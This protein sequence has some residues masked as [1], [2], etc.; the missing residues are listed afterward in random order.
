MTCDHE[1][2]GASVE[3]MAMGD[4]L[5]FAAAFAAAFAEA[6][7]HYPAIE[8]SHAI[9]EA[10][11][12]RWKREA[13][14]AAAKQAFGVAIGLKLAEISAAEQVEAADEGSEEAK[15]A[16]L[17]AHVIEAY[18]AGFD[19]EGVDCPYARDGMCGGSPECMT[20]ECGED[21]EEVVDPAD[22][23]LAEQAVLADAERA[24]GGPMRM[25]H[26]DGD[27]GHACACETCDKECE[28][29]TKMTQT[30]AM[31]NKVRDGQHDA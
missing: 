16:T 28:H 24:F 17:V 9:D 23:S 1:K 8:G 19:P 31:L 7:K 25:V 6:C 29:R 11:L 5:I 21:D 4:K 12:G 3:P 22:L 18:R 10:D 26:T 20:C 27:P 14:F 2:H 13:A 15:V 30:I